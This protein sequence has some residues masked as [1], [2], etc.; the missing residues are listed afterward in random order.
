MVAGDEVP[1][2]P[3]QVGIELNI[4]FNAVEQAHEEP[5]VLNP[6]EGDDIQ[7]TGAEL[8]HWCNGNDELE[9]GKHQEERV[10]DQGTEQDQEYEQCALDRCRQE[11]Q[12][13]GDRQF[14][15]WVAR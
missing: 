8:A 12:H 2:V 9:D 7:P 4:P 15:K 10:E 13:V 3:A 14:S 1:L 5:V 11:I 6:D